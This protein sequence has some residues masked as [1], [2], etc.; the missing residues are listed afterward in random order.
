MATIKKPQKKEDNQKDQK[1]EDN[2]KDQ[3]KEDNQKDQKHKNKMET[4]KKGGGVV[5]CPFF[6]RASSVSTVSPHTSIRLQ[7]VNS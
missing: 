4:Q 5:G 7:N 6:D 1:K 3:K 2:Q